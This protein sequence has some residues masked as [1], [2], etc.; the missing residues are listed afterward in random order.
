MVTTHVSAGTGHPPT[1]TSTKAGPWLLA[2]WL[3]KR[4]TVIQDAQ[5]FC[6][7][8]EQHLRSLLFPTSMMTML[9]SAWSRSSLSHRSTLSNV[10]ADGKKA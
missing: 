4:E 7:V 3:K 5:T 6:A 9:E 1:V 8:Q 2:Q 10:T